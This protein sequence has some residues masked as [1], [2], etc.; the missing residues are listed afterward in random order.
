MKNLREIF[1]E[2]W[3][4]L[5]YDQKVEVYNAWDEIS[6]YGEQIY[7]N[8]EEFINMFFKT[9]WD[10]MEVRNEN[11]SRTSNYFL[12]CVDSSVD[13]LFGDPD[14]E[15]YKDDI[16]KSYEARGGWGFPDFFR[17]EIE[18]KMEDEDDDGEEDSD[19]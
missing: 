15:I 1:D 10:I 8:T 2:V 11:Y 19:H 4:E 9:P 6:G 5:S 17:D 3:N 16:F 12:Y 13:T 7:P 14:L 18:N